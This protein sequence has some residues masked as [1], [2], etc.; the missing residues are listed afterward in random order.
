VY[1]SPGYTQA[2]TTVSVLIYYITF[3]K[4]QIVTYT[5]FKTY[6]KQVLHY[7]VAQVKGK[8]VTVL[9]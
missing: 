2:T 6:G 4:L 9:N 7:A 3:T 1:T 8:G 5:M